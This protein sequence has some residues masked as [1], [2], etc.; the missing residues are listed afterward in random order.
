MRLK[1]R[2]G[3][4]VL[5]KKAEKPPVPTPGLKKLFECMNRK[6]VVAI[7]YAAQGSDTTVMPSV[8]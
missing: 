2:F 4:N 7:S 3:Q 1:I 8:H 6:P 5:N